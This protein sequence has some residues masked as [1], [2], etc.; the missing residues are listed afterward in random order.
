MKR[1]VPLVTVVFLLAVFAAF[2]TLR[3]RQPW[4][5]DVAKAYCV[6]QGWPEADLSVAAFTVRDGMTGGTATAD[7]WVRGPEPMTKLR[8]TLTRRAF[9]LRWR[10]EGVEEVGP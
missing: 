6:E 1:I 3:V 4:P 8:V 5:T 7:F 9:G 10:P 2:L